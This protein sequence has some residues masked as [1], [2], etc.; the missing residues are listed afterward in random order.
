MIE[1]KC[2]KMEA[3]LLI[4]SSSGMLSIKEPAIFAQAKKGDLHSFI[5]TL[6]EVQ[7]KRCPVAPANHRLT[8]NRAHCPIVGH[9]HA[10]ARRLQQVES[11]EQF[12]N[13]VASRIRRMTEDL[14]ALRSAIQGVQGKQLQPDRAQNDQLDETINTELVI[15]FMGVLD[16]MRH[17]LW[18]D[19]EPATAKQPDNSQT[20]EGYCRLVGEMLQSFSLGTSPFTMQTAPAAASFFERID[21]VVSSRLAAEEQRRKFGT[22]AA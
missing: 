7:S 6:P 18:C 14:R 12:M 15:E 10:R 11:K 21:F 16:E 22:D 5:Q 1:T 20:G 2:P 4:E 8:R 3:N 9:F 19:A 17:F 13:D